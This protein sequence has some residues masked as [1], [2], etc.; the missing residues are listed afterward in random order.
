MADQKSG[1]NPKRERLSSRPAR[2]NVKSIDVAR[3]VGLSRTTVSYVLNNRQ[4]VSIPEST[5][6]RVMKAATELG[7]RPN[8]VARSLV[9]GRTSIIGTI[10]PVLEDSFTAEVVN[11]IQEECERHQYRVL[12][13]YSRNDPDTEREQAHLL[14]ENRAEGLICYPG[15]RSLTKTDRWLAEMLKH[16]IPCVIVDEHTSRLPVDYVVS[17]DRQGAITAV[18]HLIGLGHR[19]IAHLSAAGH[20]TPARERLEGYRKALVTAGLEVKEELI[21]GHSFDPASVAPAME[22][23]LS[24]SPLP[25]ALFAANDYLAAAAIEVLSCRSLRV[26]EDM[27]VVGFSNFRLAEYLRL[28]TVRRS[29]REMGRRAAGRLFAQLAN[30]DLRAEGIVIPT[31]L[32]IRQ[33]CGAALLKSRPG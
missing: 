12:L 19:R 8:N 25:T 5:R 23:L 21:V 10:V 20:G 16:R 13:A 26:P 24:L 32:V 9:S 1:K 17:D 14:V 18:A 2:R 22:K 3:A 4:D 27:A 28:T 7:Y 30:P 15:Y 33:S 29:P 11:G 6:K 31:E